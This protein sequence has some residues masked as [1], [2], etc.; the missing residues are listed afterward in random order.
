MKPDTKALIELAKMI[1]AHDE[2]VGGEAGTALG[3]AYAILNAMRLKA[4]EALGVK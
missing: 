2:F 1:Y 3:Q 4:R